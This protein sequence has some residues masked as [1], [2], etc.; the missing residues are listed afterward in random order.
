M[1]TNPT[2][3]PV[4]D[5]VKKNEERLVIRASFLPDKAISTISPSQLY[6]LIFDSRP[7]HCSQDLPSVPT[8]TALAVTH[9]GHII[10]DPNTMSGS[11][12]ALSAEGDATG[13][14]SPPGFSLVLITKC[15]WMA[16]PGPQNR[17]TVLW[18][19]AGHTTLSQQWNVKGSDISK[20]SE[21]WCVVPHNFSLC[22]G[23]EWCFRE[24]KFQPA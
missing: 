22:H 6:F 14:P 12:V 21:T 18:G 24:W 7:N 16:A 2:L 23:N 4:N 19:E 9:T 5:S 13:Y 11:H 1:K 3:T 15:L 8:I 17:T 20:S 10:A